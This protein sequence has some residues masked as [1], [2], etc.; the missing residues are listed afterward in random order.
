MIAIAIIGVLAALAVPAFQ[1][2]KQRS[3]ATTLVNDFR[4]I[5]SSFQRS[6]LE[7][8]R[9]PDAAGPGVVPV[10]MDGML[11]LAYTRPSPAGGSF[12]WSGPTAIIRLTGGPDNDTVMAQVDEIIDDGDLAS[13]AFSR[14]GSG[15]YH[16]RLH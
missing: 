13:G 6:N 12:S 1:R 16:L 14:I 9:W 15:G 3:L 7:L 5:E 10:D 2:L 8:G 11:P 4:Q